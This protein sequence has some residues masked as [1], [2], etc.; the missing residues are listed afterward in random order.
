MIILVV[1]IIGFLVIGFVMSFI[2]DEEYFASR[3]ETQKEENYKW[4]I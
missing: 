4:V 1:G 3:L 2:T